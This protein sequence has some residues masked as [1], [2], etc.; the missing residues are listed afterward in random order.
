M[1]VLI[2]CNTPEYFIS[3]RWRLYQILLERK[4]CI[5]MVFGPSASRVMEAVIVEGQREYLKSQGAILAK[6]NIIPSFFLFSLECHKLLSLN[7]FDR[8]LVIGSK[9]LLAISPTLLL[10]SSLNI[11][12]SLSGLGFIQPRAKGSD[13]FL[14]RV[15]RFLVIAILRVTHLRHN[16]RVLTQNQ[17]DQRFIREHCGNI[18]T[19]T[20][21][22]V[23]I[24]LM[25]FAFQ[26]NRKYDKVVLFVG[27]P[28]VDKGILEFLEVSSR[29]R[30]AFPD[31][32]F[33]VAGA[34]DYKTMSSVPALSGGNVKFLGY[35]GN[36]PEL[37]GTA[38][39]LCLPSHREGMSRVLMEGAAAGCAL[40]SFDVPGCREII[41]HGE[42]G[43]LVQNFSTD[44][45]V[46]AVRALIESPA[47]VKSMGMCGRKKAT[48]CFSVE[49]LSAKIADYIEE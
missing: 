36:I 5:R 29:L 27:R 38:S 7:S 19:A 30:H 18:K 45:L 32:N 35:V 33:L 22:G 12:Y 16:L 1:K 6:S 15:L 31:W 13:G 10:K 34:P 20:I 25:T 24:N 42:N 21:P 44:L 14:R 8:V 46:E 3:H 4:H 17:D 2:I 28:I 26:P 40:V 48:S 39:I 49:K 37:L 11:I 9:S 47:L 41:S 43:F 23:G